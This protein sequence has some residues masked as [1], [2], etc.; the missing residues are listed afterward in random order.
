MHVYACFGGDG[1]HDASF[2]TRN[3]SLSSNA[4]AIYCSMA[5]DALVTGAN[6]HRFSCGRRFGCLW[7]K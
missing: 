5:L 2:M 1:W 7:S 6:A 3:F 4:L